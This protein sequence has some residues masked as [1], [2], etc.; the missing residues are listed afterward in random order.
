MAQ[1]LW[2]GWLERLLTDRV[3]GLD[4]WPQAFELLGRPGVI[5]VFVEVADG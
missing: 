1:A 3:E 2:P 4:Q 5:K